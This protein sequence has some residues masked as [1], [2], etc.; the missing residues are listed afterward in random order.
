MMN[1]SISKVHDA[2]YFMYKTLV[3]FT[4]HHNNSKRHILLTIVN[5]I[6]L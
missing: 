5:E 1:I 4:F 6:V 2:N 3:M